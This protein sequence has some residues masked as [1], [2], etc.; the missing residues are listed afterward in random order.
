LDHV[1]KDHL[2]RIPPGTLGRDAEAEVSLTHG[3]S[4]EGLFPMTKPLSMMIYAFG[5]FMLIALAFGFFGA[6]V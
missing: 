1:G 3:H 5:C 2:P 4:S 6:P